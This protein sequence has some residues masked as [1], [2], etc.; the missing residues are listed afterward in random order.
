VGAGSGR[1]DRRPVPAGTPGRGDRAIIGNT[2]YR[3][4]TTGNVEGT[5]G[6]YVVENN[7]SVDNAVFVVNPT[8]HDDVRPQPGVPDRARDLVRLGGHELHHARRDAD[9]QRPGAVRDPGRS[10]VVSGE[11][12]TDDL[13]AYE[14]QPG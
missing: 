9:R 12:S 2:I 7:G 8:P 14:Y 1:G 10:P 6:N 5:S 3:N 11:Q 13:G 4:C